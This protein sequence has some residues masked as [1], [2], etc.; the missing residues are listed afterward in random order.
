MFIGSM[1]EKIQWVILQ[2]SSGLGIRLSTRSMG[3]TE[4]G[5]VSSSDWPELTSHGRGYFR[6]YDLGVG[7]TYF[8]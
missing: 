2:Q 7:G 1:G 5:S 4:A 8:C 3:P 6:K